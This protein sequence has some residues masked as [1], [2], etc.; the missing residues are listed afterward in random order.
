M[1]TVAGEIDETSA[2]DKVFK[3]LADPTRR[4]LLDRLRRHN[5]QTLTELCGQL[6][7]TRQSATQH[8]GVL[9]D[10][11][12]V[13]A[14][15]RGREKLH[16]LNP[17]PI[18][19]IQERWIGNFEHP[20]LRALSAVKRRAEEHHMAAK[21]AFVYVTYI[22]AAPEQVWHALTDPGLTAQYWGHSNVSDWRVGSRWE[23]LRTDGSCVADGV[24]T[25]LEATPPSRLVMTFGSP[26]D[27]DSDDAPVVTFDIE[28]HGD[29]VRLTVTH[30]KLAGQ[31]DYEAV[32]HGWPAV[33]SNLKSL[34]ETGHALPQPPWE[35]HAEL[36][37]A[38]M[39][40]NDPQ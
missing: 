9:A 15:W 34:L 2:M 31:D 7:M 37:A 3:A 36:R 24:G 18:H 39:G 17:V 20:R 38:Q 25:V 5:G 12:L 35:M 1:L 14:V 11:N 32:A 22:Q 27:E 13:A 29:I 33:L 26:G 4:T 6:G 40:R 23:H 19:Q 8:L 21:P 30:E 28:P 16:Y 10:A